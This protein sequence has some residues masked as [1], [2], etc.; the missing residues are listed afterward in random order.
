MKKNLVYFIC[1]LTAGE[2]RYKENLDL[3]LPHL[4][5]FN[6][7]RIVT[8]A[9]GE[10]IADAQGIIE[11]FPVD[12]NIDFRVVENDPDDGE[13]PYFFPILDELYSLDK[14]EAT[15]YAHAKGVSYADGHELLPNI[16]EWYTR[17]YH[18]C[19]DDIGLIERLLQEYT[20]VGCFRQEGTVGVRVS[21]FGPWH[22]SGTFF[23]Y[24]H[25]AIYSGYD[26]GVH[27]PN[28][29]GV[30]SWLG[31]SV[32]IENSACLYCSDMVEGN[33][34]YKFTPEDWARYDEQALQVKGCGGIVTSPGTA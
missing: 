18:Y 25:H 22:Y 24:N 32:R 30:E 26:Y 11:L 23:W 9:Q 34:V 3:L 19:L 33:S 6:G 5:K 14:E 4:H 2:A 8:I 21:G 12:A 13:T 16:R 27:M 1:P 7:Q 28:R 31:R 29:F 17:L 20:C 15:F 10:E